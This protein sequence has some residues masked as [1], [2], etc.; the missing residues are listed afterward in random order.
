MMQPG[1]I[2]LCATLTIPLVLLLFAACGGGDDGR[3]V[4]RMCDQLDAMEDSLVAIAELA[5]SEDGQ[6]I[7][8]LRAS[9]SDAIEA[10]IFL[11]RSTARDLT[12]TTWDRLY[13]LQRAFQPL[14][15]IRDVPDDVDLA[16]VNA[17]FS[18]H[19]DQALDANAKLARELD[20]V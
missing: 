9:R 8:E 16:E 14:N 18:L 5:G 4:S 17:F 19:A 12:R 13:A 20:C 11:D 7:A 2:R 15:V 10:I 1:G 3:S 6:T